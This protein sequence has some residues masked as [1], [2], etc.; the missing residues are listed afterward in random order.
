MYVNENLQQTKKCKKKK[1]QSLLI[2]FP[3]FMTI[4]FSLHKI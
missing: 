2:I 3:E 1:L 4:K